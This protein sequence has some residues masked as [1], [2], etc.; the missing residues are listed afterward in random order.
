MKRSIAKFLFYMFFLV[1]LASFNP[2]YAKE[3]PL[4]PDFKLQDLDQNSFSLDGFKDNSNVLLVFWTTW[5]PYCQEELQELNRSYA[6][7]AKEGMEIFAVNAGERL[8]DVKGYIKSHGFGF[9]VLLDQD[10]AVTKSYK[11]L[12]VPT[13]V[14]INKDGKI[15]FTDNYFPK[16]K[17]K[18]L[19][20]K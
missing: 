16:N 15:V 1:S 3:L 9:K 8:K 17:Y 5:C 7:F 13:Y 18:E 14:L 11:V 2:L 10:L 20:S 19:I 6:S 12:G 4:A